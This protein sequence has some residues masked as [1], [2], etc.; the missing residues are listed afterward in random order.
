MGQ[1]SG[2]LEGTGASPHRKTL[3]VA[4]WR[5]VAG[6]GVLVALIGF[7]TLLFRP[8]YQN[9][10]LQSYLEEIA[11]DPQRLQQPEGAFVAAVADR[12]AQLGIPAGIDQIRAKKSENGVFV[13]VRYFVRVD[14]LLYTVDLHFRPTAGA[15]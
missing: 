7:C 8:Y 10:K 3:G 14:L 15:R 11:Y 12:A 6:I 5:L 4:R 13:D 2:H 1:S 9:W